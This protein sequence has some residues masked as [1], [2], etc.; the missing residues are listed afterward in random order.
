MVRCCNPF[1][2]PS[3]KSHQNVANLRR[4]TR[5]QMEDAALLNIQLVVKKM[6]LCS[7]CRSDFDK[8]VRNHR[9]ELQARRREQ[10]QED[11]RREREL[12]QLE[13]QQQLRREEKQNQK[14]RE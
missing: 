14:K 6:W 8:N 7:R 1:A 10:A 9:L 4:V 13:Q 11:S 12:Q 2:K 5:K 3:H